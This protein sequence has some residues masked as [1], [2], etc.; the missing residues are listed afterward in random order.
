[1]KP[2][3]LILTPFLSL[4]LPTRTRTAMH[5]YTILACVESGA[6]SCPPWNLGSSCFL[7]TSVLGHGRALMQQTN[8]AAKPLFVCW[9]L[10]LCSMSRRTSKLHSTPSTLSVRSLFFNLVVDPRLLISSSQLFTSNGDK[11]TV[12]RPFAP[13]NCLPIDTVAVQAYSTSCTNV[14][15]RVSKWGCYLEEVESYDSKRP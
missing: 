14:G 7:R 12:D 2:G 6:L 3:S 11:Y 9:T 10:F 13:Y 15:S 4:Q 5:P 1:M 8:N